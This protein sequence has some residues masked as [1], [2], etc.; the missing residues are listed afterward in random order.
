MQSAVLIWTANLVTAASRVISIF[1][2]TVTGQVWLF[3]NISELRVSEEMID[4]LLRMLFIFIIKSVNTGYRHYG[5][6]GINVNNDYRR[7]CISSFA[8]CREMKIKKRAVSGS[9]FE[10]LNGESVA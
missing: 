3:P 5:T 2:R 4:G 6:P 8:A 10:Y 1:P 9:F 7:S